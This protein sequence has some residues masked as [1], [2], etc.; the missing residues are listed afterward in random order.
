M[1]RASLRFFPPV[2]SQLSDGRT[3]SAATGQADVVHDEILGH[4]KDAGEWLGNEAYDLV[5]GE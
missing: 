1:L 4:L 2:S 5:H 3:R